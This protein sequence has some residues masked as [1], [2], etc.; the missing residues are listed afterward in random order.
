MNG[1]YSYPA[2]VI[3]EKT[4][5]AAELRARAEAAETEL[6]RWRA[7]FGDDGPPD[8]SVDWSDLIISLMTM[9]R[10]PLSDCTP[11]TC[12][13]GKLFVAADHHL[14]SAEELATLENAGFIMDGLDGGFYSFRFGSA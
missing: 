9:A 13:D 5:E 3:H 12:E 10:H 4:R 14:F 7:L 1:E 6:A 2:E 8:M 11:V